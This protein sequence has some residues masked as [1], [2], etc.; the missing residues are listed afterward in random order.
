MT[1]NILPHWDVSNVY[2]ALGSAEF[3]EAFTSL[4]ARLS[5]FEQ[6]VGRLETL[7]ADTPTE[8]LTG[9]LNELLDRYN[10]L[11]RLG[12]TIHS[13]IHAFVSTD[14]FNTEASRKQSEFDQ[15]A[16]AFD[17]LKTRVEKWI[18][19]L[20]PV[21]AELC[22]LPGAVREHEFF[23][24][25]TAEH[26]K[27]LMSQ[28]EENLA[29]ELGLSGANAWNKL[30]G[31]VTSQLMWDIELNGEKKRL[32]MTA[33][34]NL[35]SNPD[36]EARRKGYE[37]ELAAWQTVR[38]PLAAALNGIKGTAN[39]LNRKRGYKDALQPALD[40]N[41]IDRETLDAMLT[42]MQESLPVFE[43]YFLAKAARLGEEKLPWWDLFAPVGS[44]NRRYTFAEARDMVLENFARF[45]PELSNFARQAF[46]GGWIDAEPRNGKRGGAFCMSL[47]GVRES[48]VLMNFEGSL[49]SVSTLA[50]E[51]GHGFHNHCMFKAGRSELQR[52]TPMTMAETAS[53]M[54]ETILV[55]AAL[56][57]AENEQEELAIL[58]TSILG[59][60]QVVVDIYSRF[61]FESELFIRREKAELSADEICEL[62]VNSQKKAYGNGLDHR[63]LQPY[64]W[65][66]K[67]HYYYTNLSFYNFP[68]T[69]GLLFGTGLYAI[70][71][72]RGAEFV[73]EYQKL[74]ASTGLGKAAELAARFGIDVRSTDF[75]KGSLGIIQRRIDRY[76]AIK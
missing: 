29:A 35:R 12:N 63:Y 4:K 15:I 7:N 16:V 39:T 69:F 38:E 70:Y 65:T 60:A 61:L 24:K 58:E 57:Q 34:I 51:L 9:R 53:I 22:A 54:C 74:L 48:R 28:A 68:Y 26:S 14:S 46:D 17:Q 18:G 75:W 50:H 55:D 3:D 23:L 20:R 21:L 45:S 8:Q 41:R 10:A 36:A 56:K 40:T 49:D 42:A 73:P 37:A 52:T 32:P 19:G 1:E 5:D 76:M 25:E 67:P 31:V 6:F 66:W 2:P 62:M 71:Q 33:I 44:A 47:P 27:Y 13:Y 11:L 30:Q 72:K 59:D 43:K 64:M